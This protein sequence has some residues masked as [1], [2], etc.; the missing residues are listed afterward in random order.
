MTRS[1]WIRSPGLAALIVFFSLNAVSLYAQDLIWSADYGGEYSEE[2][3]AGVRTFDGGYV[4]LG[5]TY[6]F[7]AGDHDLYVLRLDSLGDTLWSRTYGGPAT[8]RGYDIRQTAD[9]GFVVVGSTHSYGAGDADVYLLR[10]DFVGGV[11]WS[12]TFGGSGKDVGR[13]VQI[14]SDGGYII[15]GGTAS[16]GSGFD[17]FYLIKTNP[18]G[19]M[20][21]ARA[22]GG[23]GGESAFSARQT[24]DGGYVLCG[25]TGSFGQGYSSLYAVKTNA[26]GDTVWTNVY[27]GA[28]ADM[29]Y[30]VEVATDGGLVFVG[31]TASSGAGDY[32]IYLIKTDPDGGVEWERTY[33]GSATDRGYSVRPTS[34]GGFLVA[35]IT[36][37]FGA[38]AFDAFAIRTDPL[39]IAEWQQ[40]YGG[41]KSDY[42]Y[43]S[44]TDDDAWLLIGHTFSY[45]SGAS[46]V[47]INKIAA[48]GATPVDEPTEGLLPGDFVLRQNYPN[49]FNMSTTIEFELQRRADV[50]LTIH[51]ILGQVVR[52]YPYGEASPGRHTISWDGKTENGAEVASGI[53]LYS[54]EYGTLRETKKM[55]LLK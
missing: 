54:L 27:G 32:D 45:G 5:S 43:C 37:S 29:G 46:D 6:S 24:P 1:K 35:G 13:S 8:E 48:Y 26:S 16:F 34:D 44:V 42:C 15:G 31:A 18:D 21:W 25:A 17:D 20:L 40:T 47:F 50:S 28:S 3:Y 36:A 2:G 49:P 30:A 53:Y 33:G 22:Y 4:V 39:G 19:D 9:G 38:G 7:G 51:N 14:T 41:S 12:Q 10:L 55:V 11:V 23:V 52:Y